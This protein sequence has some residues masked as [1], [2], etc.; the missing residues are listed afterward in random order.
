[1]KALAPGTV[2]F[3]RHRGYGVITSVNLL[4]GW[5]SASFGDEVRTL[6]LNLSH[7]ELQHADGAQ[8]RI[9]LQRGFRV[10]DA[11]E[12]LLLRLAY[13]EGMSQSRI[14]RE[15]G[16]SQI[17]VSRLTRRALAKLREEIGRT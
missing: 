12:R 7:D 5:V 14:G 15:V 8:D 2:I 10:L 17:H 16:L 4:T 9:A 3:H 6:D 13:F 11:R 1:M